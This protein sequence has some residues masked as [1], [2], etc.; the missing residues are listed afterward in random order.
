MPA[1]PPLLPV[2][3]GR[4]SFTHAHFVRD[5]I[6]NACARLKT[7]QAKSALHLFVVHD[8]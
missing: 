7:H 3:G 2:D 5:L 8:L 4:G 6:G 1:V